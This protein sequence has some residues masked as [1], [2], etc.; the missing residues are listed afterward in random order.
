MVMP[1]LPQAPS[2]ETRRQCTALRLAFLQVTGL[3]H[4]VESDIGRLRPGTEATAWSAPG[5]SQKE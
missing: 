1:G 3:V 2:A 5:A 4:D